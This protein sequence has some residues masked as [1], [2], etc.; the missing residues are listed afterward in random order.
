MSA[1]LQ[2][3]FKTKLTAEINNSWEL[4]AETFAERG[5]CLQKDIF[6]FQSGHDNLSL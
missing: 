6:T 5:R 2:I 3:V 1:I 4:I